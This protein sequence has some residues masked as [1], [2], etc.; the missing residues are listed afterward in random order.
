MQQVI[1]HLAQ[2]KLKALNSYLSQT[3][4]GLARHYDSQQAAAK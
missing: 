4:Y 2:Q 1:A 3:R